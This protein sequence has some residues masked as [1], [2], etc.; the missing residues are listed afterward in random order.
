MINR[1]NF[2][3]LDSEIFFAPLVPHSTVKLHKILNLFLSYV[4]K[5][6]YSFIHIHTH[7]NDFFLHLTAFCLNHLKFAAI[8]VLAKSAYAQK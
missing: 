2:I 3:L 7:R 4:L 1:P 8:I 6:S 5:R